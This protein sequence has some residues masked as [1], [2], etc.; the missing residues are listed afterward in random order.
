MQLTNYH[1]RRWPYVFR[2]RSKLHGLQM[3]VTVFIDFDEEGKPSTD[4]G[5]LRMSVDEWQALR[6]ALRPGLRNEPLSAVLQEQIE[7]A[8]RKLRENNAAD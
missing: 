4:C 6:A 3:H 2:L 7:Q 5:T 1:N 8:Q